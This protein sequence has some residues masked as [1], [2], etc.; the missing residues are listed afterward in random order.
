MLRTVLILYLHINGGADKERIA[1]KIIF[2]NVC[3]QH[4]LWGRDM[5]F[6]IYCI[7][8][9]TVWVLFNDGFINRYKAVNV[10]HSTVGF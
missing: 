1:R 8:R 9:L 2:L 3:T 7:S 5:F 10:L 6:I 4:L